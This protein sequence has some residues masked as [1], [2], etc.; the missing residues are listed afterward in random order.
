MSPEVTL[1]RGETLPP[2]KP[3]PNSSAS[4]SPPPAVCCRF[5]VPTSSPTRRASFAPVDNVPV[6]ADYVVGPGDEVMIRAWG[7]I[8][9][10]Y[11]AT[12][13]RNGS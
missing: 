12:V 2:P 11:R 5:S 9:V 7:S 3:S 13:D 10:D 4:S 1:R 8:D 6:S